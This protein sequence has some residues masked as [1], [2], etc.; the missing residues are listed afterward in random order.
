MQGIATGPQI[1]QI[2]EILCFFDN[3]ANQLYLKTGIS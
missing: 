2:H 3:Q 1:S